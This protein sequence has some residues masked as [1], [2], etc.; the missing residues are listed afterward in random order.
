MYNKLVAS[1]YDGF[2]YQ[3]EKQ[4]LARRRKQL[5]GPVEGKVLEVGAGTG[6]NFDYY[7]PDTQ[8]I[9]IEPDPAMYRKAQRKL[10][11]FPNVELLPLGIGDDALESE[12]PAGSLDAVVCTL[13]LCTLPEPELSFQLFK[14]WLKPGGQLRV[15]EH[16]RSPRSLTAGLQ[17]FFTPP[18]KRVALGCHLNRPTDQM[19]KDAGFQLKE[20]K[21]FSK[22]FP[23][24]LGV[25]VNEG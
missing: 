17:D 21:Y 4:G 6:V 18:W 11:D 7:P 20:E 2:M 24:Y 10:R 5:L 19:I 14:K 12:I 22:Y 23:W 9:A 13:V 3:A 1:I 25:F 16:I 8:V 15:L